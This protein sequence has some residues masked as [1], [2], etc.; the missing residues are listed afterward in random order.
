MLKEIL[1]V[2]LE[3]NNVHIAY[4]ADKAPLWLS[5]EGGDLN[6]FAEFLEALCPGINSENLCVEEAIRL[7]KQLYR[8]LRDEVREAIWLELVK[9][10]QTI[11]NSFIY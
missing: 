2:H 4:D 1:Y 6:D 7:Q 11:H 3:E 5:E 9:F 10:R 8:A